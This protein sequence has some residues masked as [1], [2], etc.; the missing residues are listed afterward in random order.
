M[1]PDRYLPF[2]PTMLNWIQQTLDAHARERRAVSSFNFPRLPH[3]FSQGLLDAASVVLTERLP[4]PPL[5]AL[6]LMEF[7]DFDKQPINGITYL[8]T[9]FLQW[10]PAA[11]DES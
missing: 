10:S 8:K 2:L 1:E 4:R 11:F 9:Y 5:S 7:T 3:Y 6:G